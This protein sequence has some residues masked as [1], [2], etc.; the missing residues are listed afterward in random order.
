MAIKPTQ[1][2][3][4]IETA[5]DG[6]SREGGISLHQ[7]QALDECRDGDEV[8]QAGTLDTETRWQDVPESEIAKMEVAMCFMDDIGLKYYLPAFMV[9]SIKHHETCE[10][11]SANHPI[12]QL[13][14]KTEEEK[15]RFSIFNTPQKKAIRR[16]LEYMAYFAGE[17]ADS[18]AAKEALN[19]YWGYVGKGS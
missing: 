1:L 19:S 14:A 6:V 11:N 17:E 2:I 15:K 12:Y 13:I 18:D 7:A 8:E 5:F 16:Y 4:E 9:Y 10:T 3:R